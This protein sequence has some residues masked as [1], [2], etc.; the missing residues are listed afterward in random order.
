MKW[1]GEQIFVGEALAGEMV[2]L[3]PIDD[4]RWMLHLGV[5]RL[6]VLHERSRIV[7]PL[8]SNAD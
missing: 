1:D 7:M 4:W 5:V 8:D 2:G 6:G 3:K